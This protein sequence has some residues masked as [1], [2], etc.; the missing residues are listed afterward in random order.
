MKLVIDLNQ[1]SRGKKNASI[2]D[3]KDILKFFNDYFLYIF[4][5]P[6]SKDLFNKSPMLFVVWYEIVYI[7]IGYWLT[8]YLLSQT[9]N[10]EE[11]SLRIFLALYVV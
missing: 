6:Q 8:L 1:D 2:W 5:L 10:K 11:K 9:Y 4:K 7:A 3:L